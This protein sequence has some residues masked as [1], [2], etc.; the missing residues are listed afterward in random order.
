MTAESL[1]EALLNHSDVVFNDPYAGECHGRIT[2]VI[3]REKNGK[4]VVSAE[5]QDKKAPHSVIIAKPE[6]LYLDETES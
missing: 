4:I 5:M 1:K 3:Y 6:R 2:A